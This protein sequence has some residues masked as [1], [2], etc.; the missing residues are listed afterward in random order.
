MR[1]LIL[2][3][4]ERNRSELVDFDILDIPRYTILSHTWGSDHIEDSH[5][6]ER[7]DLIVHS[8]T[9]NTDCLNAS[10]HSDI[11]DTGYDGFHTQSLPYAPDCLESNPCSSACE[12]GFWNSTSKG[13]FN[14]AEQASSDRPQYFWVDTF[15]INHSS[16]GSISKVINFICHWY[17][18]PPSCCRYCSVVLRDGMN[19]IT[20]ISNVVKNTRFFQKKWFVCG[21]TVLPFVAPRF[22][23]LESFMRFF[24]LSSHPSRSRNGQ[25]SDTSMC[26]LNG[27]AGAGEQWRLQRV[28]LIGAPQSTTRQGAENLNTHPLPTL[29]CPAAV[30]F[31]ESARDAEDPNI[32]RDTITRKGIISFCSSFTEITALICT[33]GAGAGLAMC[34]NPVRLGEGSAISP[35]RFHIPFKS[36]DDG[37]ITIKVCYFAY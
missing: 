11:L 19:H 8:R 21:R 20:W 14:N 26:W 23:F 25:L 36:F 5:T 7:D 28:L 18:N 16:I 27:N 17:G 29:V 2:N 13:P 31:H 37:Q 9:C 1:L 10:T 3:E 32:Q 33:G 4:G 12:P 30:E 35:Q 22:T 6:S 24:N 15:G 34:F